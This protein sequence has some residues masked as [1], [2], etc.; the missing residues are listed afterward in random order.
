L[1]SEVLQHDILF[2]LKT[3]TYWSMSLLILVTP[4]DFACQSRPTGNTILTDRI[5]LPLSAASSLQPYTHIS[6]LVNNNKQQ[7]SA[8][9]TEKEL[10]K[11]Q[12]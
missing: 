9:I 8:T 5:I 11:E 1:Y 12:Y 7:L 2:S 3:L 10:K 4:P 6:M